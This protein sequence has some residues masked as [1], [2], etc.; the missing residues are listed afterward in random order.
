[1]QIL[2]NNLSKYK[3]TT[4]YNLDVIISVGYRV[5]SKRGTDYFCDGNKRII[6]TL[7]LWFLNEN[8]ILYRLDGKKRLPDNTHVALT[9]MIAESS[10]DEK[11]IM[12]NVVV[13]MINQNN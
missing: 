4:I 9:L 6:V 8:R 2:H 5:K 1:M 3:Q 12:V 11:D 10:P 13:N 7:F